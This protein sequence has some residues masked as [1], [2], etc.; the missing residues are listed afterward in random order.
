MP[1]ELWAFLTGSW[2]VIA[3]IATVLG[4]LVDFL[5][6]RTLLTERLTGRATSQSA[7]E[8]TLERSGLILAGAGS[9]VAVTEAAHHHGVRAPDADFDEAGDPPPP[10]GELAGLDDLPDLPDA[11]DHPLGAF[12]KILDTLDPTS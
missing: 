1:G 6:L 2:P 3:V 5:G 4:L 12:G 9:T 11:P 8:S 10:Q 7:S